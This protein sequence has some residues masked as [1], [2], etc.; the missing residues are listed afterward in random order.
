[1]KQLTNLCSSFM[2]LR[3]PVIRPWYII[4]EHIHLHLLINTHI[5]KL[6]YACSKD[7]YFHNY[8]IQ[9]RSVFLGCFKKICLTYNI[10]H[11]LSN[12]AM[13]FTVLIRVLLVKLHRLYFCWYI[14][15]ARVLR[16]SWNLFHFKLDSICVNIYGVV[17]SYLWWIW[18][19]VVSSYGLCPQ[20][21][22][23]EI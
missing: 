3:C 10:A 13:G 23:G 6:V 17:T 7:Q 5:S 1:M 12:L 8:N 18:L 16:Y 22:N 19:G 4:H 21:N 2:F 11:G 15:I 14:S 9:N 20:T